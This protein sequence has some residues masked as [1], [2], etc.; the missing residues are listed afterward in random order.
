MANQSTSVSSQVLSAYD[1]Q[2]KDDEAE[3]RT[4]GARAKATNIAEI[5]AGR[6][7]DKVLECGAGEGSLLEA[8]G[9]QNLFK[10]LYAIEISPSGLERI[11]ERGIETLRQAELFDGYDIPFP[12]D[13]FDLTYCSHVIEHVEHPRLLLRELRRVSR[14]QIFEVPL[15]YV[16]GVDDSVSEFLSHGHINIFTPSIFKFLLKSEGFQ[17][18]SELERESSVE[19]I[20]YN[21][22]KNLGLPKTFGRELSLM[23]MPLKSLVKRLIR[24]RQNF[25]EFENYTYTCLSEGTGELEIFAQK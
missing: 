25:T 19:S 6:S 4:L 2:Y 1:E 20:R 11:R 18:L 23:M 9:K 5:C 13:T 8:V 15:D 24:G 22:Y 3:W 17:I 14:H 10:D 21:W 7:Y 12:D 16:V